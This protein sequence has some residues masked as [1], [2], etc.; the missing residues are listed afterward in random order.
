MAFD[1]PLYSKTT[2]LPIF[3]KSD[4][5]P[6]FG[7]PDNCECCGGGA[8][9]ETPCSDCDGDQPKA[10]VTIITCTIPGASDLAGEYD[11]NFWRE[12]WSSN[13]PACAWYWNRD[14]GLNHYELEVY[15]E[16]GWQEIALRTGSGPNNFYFVTPDESPP[17]VTCN[18]VTGF[19][20]GTY[21]VPIS[22]GSADDDCV[23]VVV[24]GG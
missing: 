4:D 15:I 1:I 8:A 11:W 7:D 5:K 20:E 18:P 23:A 22:P 16:D 12:E 17:N 13:P 9:S 3:A 2:D 6:M 24:L 10:S 19:L 14:S 21:Y